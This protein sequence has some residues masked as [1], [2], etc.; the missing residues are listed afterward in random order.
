M[1]LLSVENISKS[2]GLKELFTAVSF[3]LQKGDKVGLIGVNG[4]GK[5]TFLNVIAGREQPDQGRVTTAQDL[6]IEYLPQ[7][8]VFAQSATVLQQVF[9]GSSPVME[10][11]REYQATLAELELNPTDSI[12]QKKLISLNPR[13]DQLA[14]WQQESEAKAILTKLGIVD[15]Q[16][17]VTTLSGGQR[18][19]VAL[20]STLINP[21]DL[22]I[23]DEPTNQID[24]DT[25]AWLEEYLNKRKGALLMVTHDRYFLERVVN[26]IF[27]LEQA[28]LYSY[29]H[30]YSAYLA[31]KLEREELQQAEAVKRQNIMR[32]ELAWL[33]RGCRARST[34]QK[35]RIQRLAKLQEEQPKLRRE[36]LEFAAVTSRLGKKVIELAGISKGYGQAKLIEDFSYVLVRNDRIGI[37]GPNGSGKTTLL[38]LISGRLTPEQGS[39]EIGQTVKLGYYQQE[40]TELDDNLRVIE[41]IKEVG[42]FV[43]LSA[44]QR[45]SAAQMLERFLFRPE[46]HWKYIADLSGGEKR[47]LYL[48]RI[49]MEAPNVL[50]LDEPT[51]DLDI[52][53]LTILE[54]YL[55]QF[56]GA[57]VVVSHD[58][59]FLDRIAEKIFAFEGGGQLNQYP[60]HYS[61][62]RQRLAEKRTKIA[63]PK[64]EKQRVSPTVKPKERPRK[65]S[66]QEQQ[67]FDLIEEQID[68]VERELR[69]LG[70]SINQTGSD[71]Q[72]LQ[73][74]VVKQQEM[75][76]ELEYLMERWSYLNQLVEEIEQNKQRVT[77]GA[78]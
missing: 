71:Y 5:S 27:E 1:H 42:E 40:N 35:A 66:Y 19:R 22:L 69:E 30:N 33:R 4:T 23:L 12:L 57:V 17:N 8:P 16:A 63:K 59:Y 13:M 11:L 15:F 20:A 45:I 47:R 54:D 18:K 73:E 14:A 65:L 9:K 72:L 64:A 77:G 28:T 38:K 3:G 32:Q 39:I 58:R 48:L 46:D 34:K 21:A 74:L 62:Y 31:A 70:E 55:E 51:N 26:R 2:Y 78:R 75:E 6:V 67:E 44:Q 37:V 49:L 7:N 50:L 52:K 76:A 25:V 60:G 68:Q 41:Y 10:L 36:E 61:D 43:P 24:N 56:P 53:T 29:H